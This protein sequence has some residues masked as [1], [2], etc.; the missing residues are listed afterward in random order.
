MKN[1][2]K[3]IPIEKTP[4]K[5]HSTNKYDYHRARHACR[6]K[7]EGCISGAVGTWAG[8]KSVFPHHTALVALFSDNHISIEK[9][10][11]LHR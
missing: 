2:G 11:Q 3:S 9:A 4:Q 8:E 10:S 7:P 5:L 1:K 6:E